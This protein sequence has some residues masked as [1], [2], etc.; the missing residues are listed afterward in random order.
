MVKNVMVNV[1]TAISRLPRWQCVT[2]L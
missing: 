2:V 1:N